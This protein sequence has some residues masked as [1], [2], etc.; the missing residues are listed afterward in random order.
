ML[1]VSC[2]TTEKCDAYSFAEY[3]Y[4][5]VIGYSDKIPTLGEGEI[6]LPP[7]KYLLKAYKGDQITYIRYEERIQG[8]TP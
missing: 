5:E 1:L 4:I 8:A 2:K 6:H 3:E 7:G